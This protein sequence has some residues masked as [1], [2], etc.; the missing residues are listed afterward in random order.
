MK[1]PVRRFTEWEMWEKVC[2]AYVLAVSFTEWELWEKV[3]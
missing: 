2:D 1:F 3:G